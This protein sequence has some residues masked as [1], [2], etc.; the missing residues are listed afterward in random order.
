MGEHEK[1]EARHRAGWLRNGL[2]AAAALAALVTIS[3][4]K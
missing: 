4:L 2:I 3:V 1:A